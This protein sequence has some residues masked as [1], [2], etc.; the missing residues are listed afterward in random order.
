MTKDEWI[1]KRQENSEISWEDI[2]QSGYDAMPCN[3]QLKGCKGWKLLKVQRSIMPVQRKVCLVN[4]TPPE[5][6]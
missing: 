6:A 2:L 1:A 4:S 3:C 5:V